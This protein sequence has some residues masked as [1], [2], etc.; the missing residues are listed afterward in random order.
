MISDAQSKTLDNEALFRSVITD[1]YEAVLFSSRQDQASEQVEDLNIRRTE[2]LSSVDDLMKEITHPLK[3]YF[4]SNPSESFKQ[5]N[6]SITKF[7]RKALDQY[8]E[9]LSLEFLSKEKEIEATNS[10]Y[11]TKAQ[12]GMESFLFSQPI[13]IDES[14]TYIKYMSGGYQ[15]VR[16]VQ[17]QGGISYE[18]ILN[19]AKIKLLEESLYFSKLYKGLRIPIRQSTS[20]ITKESVVDRE[21]LDTY[22]LVS[23]EFAHG[24]T[25]AFFRDEESRSEFRF[26]LSGSG[27]QAVFAIEYKD[28]QESVDINSHPAL[29][30]YVDSSAVKEALTQLSASIRLLRANPVKI[31]ALTL[32]GDDILTTQIFRRLS[33][34][35]F[36]V[37]GEKMKEGILPFM[38][39]KHVLDDLE[40]DAHKIAERLKFLEFYDQEIQKQVLSSAH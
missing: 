14:A 22:M 35:V 24:T 26:V 3:K 15:A 19:T 20:W 8:K 1:L 11:V 18:I 21:K 16:K 28:E 36:E 27:D 32:D 39:K 5:A 17:A 31:S 33:D 13:P 37:L 7:A 30:N 23:A 38:K 10:S 4:E 40:L 25:I 29:Q 12:K 6:E 9:R 2:K 34:R